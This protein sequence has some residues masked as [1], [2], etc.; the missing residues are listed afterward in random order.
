MKLPAG[1]QVVFK[2]LLRCYHYPHLLS[3]TSSIKKGTRP[4]AGC[5]VSDYQARPAGKNF[6]I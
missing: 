2:A 6:P 5:L 1:R 3:V 4:D